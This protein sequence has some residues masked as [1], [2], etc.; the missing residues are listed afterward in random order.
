MASYVDNFTSL[1]ADYVRTSQEIRL[2]SSTAC[3]GD[4]FTF[5]YG[6]VVHTNHPYEPARPVMEIA[7][8]FFCR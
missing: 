7:L 8:L 6:D 3:Y 4:G 5:L 1:Y 2:F